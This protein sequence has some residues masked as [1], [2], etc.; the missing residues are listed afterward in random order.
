MFCSKCGSQT[1]NGVCACAG[2]AETPQVI[3]ETP[4][5]PPQQFAEPQAFSAVIPETPVTVAPSPQVAPQKSSWE[6]AGMSQTPVTAPPIANVEF[7]PTAAPAMVVQKSPKKGLFIALAACLGGLGVLGVA[8]LLVVNFAFGDSLAVSRA[9]TN[10][11]NEA[12]ARL[13]S[14]PFNAIMLLDEVSRAGMFEVGMSDGLGTDM[15]ISMYTDERRGN[16]ALIADAAVFGETLEAAFFM[17]R[18]RVIIDVDKFR[19]SYGFRYDR[20]E[21]DMRVLGR[22]AGLD[23]RTI[24][25]IVEYMEFME[26]QISNPVDYEA[27]LKPYNDIVQRHMLRNEGNSERNAEVRVGRG[28]FV[29]ARR[30]TYTFD[31][32]AVLALLTE[33]VDTLLKDELVLDTIEMMS[34]MDGMDHMSVREFEREIENAIREFERNVTNFSLELSF[35]IGARNRLVQIEADLD[36]TV[37][38]TNWNGDTTR[39]RQRATITLNM[40]SSV[41]STWSLTVRDNDNR[42]EY[43]AEWRYSG[44]DASRIRHEFIVDG[45]TYID[46]AW[47]PS[48]GFFT[49]IYDDGMDGWWSNSFEI[50]GTYRQ[51]RDGFTI[52]LEFEGI[53]FYAMAQKGVAVPTP[54][55]EN[56]ISLDSWYE[57][58]FDEFADI[59]DFLEEITDGLFGGS[60]GSSNP[61]GWDGDPTWDSPDDW[62]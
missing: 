5:A 52:E 39:E 43:V 14:S 28:E 44:A 25:M 58:L 49:L 31:D 30:V 50:D 47:N 48:N 38:Y 26:T 40:G 15:S 7:T 42:A 56:F 24:N 51:T 32:A 16:Y 3:P 21:D 23:N 22:D 53:E 62:W 18:Q 34:G 54:A 57:T 35:F 37:R 17:N 8:A 11:E 19:N 13:E 12:L 59:E 61:W 27:W 36:M 9:V 2:T 20:F 10:F 46:L 45:H 33:L 41:N 1:E 55:S 29:N 4:Q 60:M 6:Q